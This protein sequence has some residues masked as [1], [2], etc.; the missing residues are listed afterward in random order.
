MGGALVDCSIERE[1]KSCAVKSPV[2]W[3]CRALGARPLRRKFWT[4]WVMGRCYA[5]EAAK[6]RQEKGLVGKSHVSQTGCNLSKGHPP[7]VR[8]RWRRK[9]GALICGRR[10][11]ESV[12]GDVSGW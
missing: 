11:A 1:A 8:G 4:S 7:R 6:S 12:R 9:W 3:K 5:R 10:G 2:I